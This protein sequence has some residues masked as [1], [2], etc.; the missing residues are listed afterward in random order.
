MA[1]RYS[2]LASWE[3]SESK[4]V[5]LQL[6]NG[7]SAAAVLGGVSI[8]TSMG[9]APLEGLMMGIRTGDVDPALAE[10]LLSE[11][12]DISRVLSPADYNCAQAVMQGVYQ[13]HGQ[14][15]TLVVPKQPVIPDL[16]T[17]EESQLLFEQGAISLDWLSLRPG[18]GHVVITAIGSYHL[19]ET[20]HASNRPRER[21]I[22]HLVV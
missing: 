20:V 9:L 8:D 1:E 2:T 17:R 11:P 22:P 18:E 16:F 19:E 7:Y 3:L 12:S 10:S 21:D 4:R 14:I 15:W 13:S 5:T 6:G